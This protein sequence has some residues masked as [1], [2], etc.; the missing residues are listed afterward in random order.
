ML[1]TEALGRR[2][3]DLR[4]AKGITQRD[5]AE[6]LNVSGQAVSNWE[7]GITPPDLDN[8]VAVAS[9]FGVLTDDLLR[10]RRQEVF[11]GVDG[12]G[13]KTEFVAV[14]AEGTVLW[15]RV[16]ESSNPNDLGYDQASA[17]IL[18]G[19]EEAMVKFPDIK[20]IFCGISG[21]TAGDYAKRLTQELQRRYPRRTI[22]IETDAC[23]LLAMDESADMAVISGTGSVVFLR[24][25]GK[26]IRLGGWGYLF[27]RAGSAYD[28]GREALQTALEEEDFG[29]PFSCLGNLVRQRLGCTAVWDKIGAVY[30]G[31][32]PLVAS[33]AS[34]VFDAL[35]QGDEKAEK[36]VND[37]AAALARLL[38]TGV[39]RYGVR[40]CAV[41]SGGIFSNYGEFLAPRIKRLTDVRLILPELP[42]VY[43]ACR[44]ACVRACGGTSP[45]FFRNFK[46]TYGGMK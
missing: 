20:G 14:T 21:I 35:A 13:T 10:P 32:K 46:T 16:S 31:G 17:R 26:L 4:E 11:L 40:P 42:P 27:D 7:R 15:Q 30:S 34:A 6:E 45:E 44:E 8:L 24:K 5:L 29:L 43:G 2:I 1:D 25:D 41:A 12:G 33:L 39:K 38:E 36:I 22:G 18:E 9:Y 23:N 28:L 19:I 3:R 37:T